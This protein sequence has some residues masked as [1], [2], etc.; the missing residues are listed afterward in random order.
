MSDLV[1]GIDGGGT[2][3]VCWLAP[4]VD[5]G[6]GNILGRGIAG[7]GNPRAAGFETAQANIDTAIAAAFADAK[8]PRTTVAAACLSLAGAGRASEQ[9]RIALWAESREIATRVI[10]TDDAEPIL[11]AA[12]DGQNGIALIAG[13]GSLCVGRTTAGRR[14]RAGGWGYLLGDEGSGY[15]IGLAALRAAARAADGRGPQTVLLDDVLHRVHAATPSELIQRV[16]DIRMTRDRIALLAEAV[17]QRAQSDEV[18]RQIVQDAANGLAEL[19]S[20]VTAKLT[21]PAAS[22]VLALAG[23]VLIHQPDYGERVLQALAASGSS[24]ARSLAVPEP[25]AGAVAIARSLA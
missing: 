19:V 23:G 4:L 6:S 2:K 5:D 20:N 18:A 9:E 24:P 11:A 3:T 21:L 10:V 22:F 7:P 16:Y 14:A 1:V 17:F 13:T 15:A 8:L 25:A 12:G